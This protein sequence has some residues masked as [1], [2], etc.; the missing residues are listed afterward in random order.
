MARGYSGI[1]FY[2]PKHI[3]NLG[4]AFRSAH[5]FGA[6]F[7]GL[8]G[9][10]YSRQPADTTDAGRHV[11]IFTFADVGSFRDSVPNRSTIVSVEV[12]GTCDLGRFEHPE[13]AVYIL[14]GEDRSVPFFPGP[15]VRIES[16]HCLNMAMAATLIL[17]DRMRK[18]M[19]QDRV[20][21]A[22]HHHARLIKAAGGEP[23]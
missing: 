7:I 8:I 6:D 23:L 3:G 11:P 16:L 21:A 22:L 19:R 1:V 14:G 9:P 12:D 5:C 17:Y 20:S 13:S 18:R 15:R 4:A 2:E 10:R